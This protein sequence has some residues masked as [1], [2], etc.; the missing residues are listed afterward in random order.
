MKNTLTVLSIS[1]VEIY[2]RKIFYLITSVSFVRRKCLFENWY[3]YNTQNQCQP[4]YNS[5][6]YCDKNSQRLV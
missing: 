2:N 5:M 6:D 1:P 3:G 4:L